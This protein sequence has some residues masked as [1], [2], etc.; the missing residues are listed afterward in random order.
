[1]NRFDSLHILHFFEYQRCPLIK[2]AKVELF[3]RITSI[4]LLIEW[5]RING[6]VDVHELSV[7]LI[8]LVLPLLN[9]ALQVG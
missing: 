4:Q 6:L 1:M 5:A 3:W 8:E 7:M 9:P 2:I